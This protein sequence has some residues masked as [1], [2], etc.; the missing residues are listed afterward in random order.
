MSHGNTPVISVQ[1]RDFIRVDSDDDGTCDGCAAQHDASLCKALPV[2][3]SR[4]YNI[5]FKEIT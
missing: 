1:C 5:I 4:T 2:C 3:S